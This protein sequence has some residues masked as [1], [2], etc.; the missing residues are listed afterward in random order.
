L[1]LTLQNIGNG[2]MTNIAFQVFGQF[3]TGTPAYTLMNNCPATLAGGSA[4]CTVYVTFTP[5]TTTQY[6]ASIRMTYGTGTATYVGLSGTGVNASI[7]PVSIAETI[8]LNDT[9]S[10]AAL[11]KMVPVNETITLNDTMS[12]ATLAKMVPVNETITLNDTMS[13]ASLAKMVPVNETIT[14]ND[15]MSSAMLQLTATTATIMASSS[16]I[17]LGGAE[18]ITVQVTPTAATGTVNLYD[19]TALLATG[20]LLSG[21]FIYNTSNLTAGPHSLH[22][23]YL[24]SSAYAASSTGTALVQVQA[25]LTITANNASRAF[26]ASNPTL[27]Y[28]VTGYTNGDTSAALIGAPTL[29][30]TAV[31]HSLAG[32]YPITVAQGT[33]TAPSY[34]NLSFVPGTLTITGNHS[35]VIYF[36]PFPT[37]ISLSVKTLTLTG[38]T[39]SALPI[40]YQVSGPATLSGT[41]L[42]LTGPGTVTVKA[43][44]SGSP[45]FSPATSV[46]QSFNV[47]TP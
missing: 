4:P 15:T 40:T 1:T 16:A 21:H 44:Q 37:P 20:A 36:L 18:N 6:V 39:S 33:L 19:G 3:P 10:S 43:T 24:G 17:P 35:Q 12:S 32:S 38:T 25:T 29:T 42:T 28:T 8:T 14:L 34:Y 46:A 31:T 11:A 45:T 22:A 7:I 47:V 26:A 27:G 2:T 41:T 13:N 9:M 23:S 5:P 30:T